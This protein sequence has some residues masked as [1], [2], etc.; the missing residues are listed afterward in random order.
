MMY[1]IHSIENNLVG[2]YL[3]LNLLMLNTTG[4]I[5]ADVLYSRFISTR[6]CRLKVKLPNEWMRDWP[7]NIVN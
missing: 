7:K 1:F 2:I 3:L 6:T 4:N 5:L